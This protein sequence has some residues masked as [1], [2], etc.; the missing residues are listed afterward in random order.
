MC[1]FVVTILKASDGPD[2]SEPVRNITFIR[3]TKHVDSQ[4]LQN[5]Q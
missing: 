5:S 2:D 3:C 4:S 1:A